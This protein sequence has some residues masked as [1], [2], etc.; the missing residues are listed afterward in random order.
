MGARW[1][2]S[3]IGKILVGGHEPTALGL[4]E[5]P[6]LVI[7]HALP[8]LIT[9]RQRI[10][11]QRGQ[12]LCDFVGQI[13]VHLKADGHY[14]ASLCSAVTSAQAA[15]LAANH[16]AA[17]MS[18]AVNCG[19][20]WMI[21]SGECPSAM[22]PTM[23]LTGTRVPLMHGLPWWILGSM[24]IRSRQFILSDMGSSLSNRN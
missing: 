24:L 13:F 10:M 18:S 12:H 5:P 14:S 3:Q 22:L 8:S 4:D 20:D 15:A 16:N 2:P 17:V 7:G 9:D 1:A 21:R 23:T 6:Q 11:T 19:Q